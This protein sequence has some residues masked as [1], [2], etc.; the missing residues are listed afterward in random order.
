MFFAIFFFLIPILFF[1][2]MVKKTRGFIFY[3]SSR[4]NKMWEDYGFRNNILLKYISVSTYS[5]F[6]F[7]T[8]V[9][10]V[11]I[12]DKAIHIQPYSNFK[13]NKFGLTLI[14]QRNEN[15]EEPLKPL[16]ILHIQ[17]VR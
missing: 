16:N 6:S 17:R 8:G 5:S 12:S 3:S 4:F 11:Y 7:S 15:Y 2:L 1:L 14:G 9:Y 10:D 13:P